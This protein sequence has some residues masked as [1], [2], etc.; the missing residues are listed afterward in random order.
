MSSYLERHCHRIQHTAA[1]DADRDCRHIRRSRS[2]R[3]RPGRVLRRQGQRRRRRRRHRAVPPH[4]SAR[5]TTRGPAPADRCCR[6]VRVE[7]STPGRPRGDHRQPRRH[8]AR[9]RWGD[10]RAAAAFGV[11]R[12]LPAGTRWPQPAVG[13]HGVS[14]PGPDPTGG[15]PQDPGGHHPIRG[16]DAR[17]GCGRDRLR[18]R[19]WSGRRS[20]GAGRQAGDHPGSRQLLERVR[21]RAVRAAGISE[22]FPARRVLPLRRRHGQHRC[23]QHRGRRQHRQL[24]Q[25]VAD[26]EH[27]PRLLGQRLWAYR[28]RHPGVR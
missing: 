9:G 28:R 11:V 13:R 10:R 19:R 2:E 21:L 23:G 18:Q 7:G 22:A 6:P 17:V 5:G 14:R 16:D 26:P 1:G 12:L 25:L 27:R 20:A 4:A 8:L 24:V 15:R 3:E